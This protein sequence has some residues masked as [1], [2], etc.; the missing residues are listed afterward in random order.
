MIVT[1][2]TFPPSFPGRHKTEESASLSETFRSNVVQPQDLNL[3][4]ENIF[5]DLLLYWRSTSSFQIVSSVSSN[6]FLE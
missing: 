5:S 3:F 2:F 4:S 1:D 6:H